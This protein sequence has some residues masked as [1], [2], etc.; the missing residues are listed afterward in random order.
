MRASSTAYFAEIRPDTGL[1]RVVFL[2]AI[3]FAVLGALAIGV[4][5]VPIWARIPAL[6]AWSALSYREMQALRRGWRRSHGLR[7]VATGE[8]EVRDRHG[9]WALA[10]LADGSV[11][12][13]RFGWLRLV[14]ADGTRIHE[15]IRG[16]RRDNREWRRLHVIW[17]HV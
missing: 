12:L 17:R 5:T 1:R 10:Q 6:V 14:A 13:R 16:S 8:V 2:S 11:L 4:A 7:I 3:G 15:L 9:N